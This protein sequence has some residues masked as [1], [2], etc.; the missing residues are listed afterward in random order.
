MDNVLITGGAGF[1]GRAFAKYLLEKTYAKRICIYSRDE[2]KQAQMKA[3]IPDPDLRLR[4]FIGDVRDEDRL[5]RAMEGVDTVIHGAA[6]KRIEVARYNPIELCKT[7]IIG[8]INVVQA[9]ADAGVKKAVLLSTDKACNPCSAYGWSKAMAE[10]IFV[11]ANEST[12]AGGPI[13]AVTRYGNVAGSTGSVIPIWKNI[14]KN[15]DDDS[16][17]IPIVPVSDP[18]ATR[19]WM[20]PNEAVWLVA[21]TIATM[22]G[23]ET[24]TPDLPAFRLGDLAQAMGASM[25]ITGLGEY[26]KRHES[27]R[28]G[29]SSETARRL[30]ISELQRMLRDV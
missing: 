21:Q 16:L 13:F 25:N 6:L 18:D 11:S 7:N 9:S 5:R 22:V 4:F 15:W 12:R 14:I 29:Q 30:T 2:W 3:D 1:F 10:N 24:V 17:A 23:G 28:D 27:M 8:T 20:W 26:E 19:F